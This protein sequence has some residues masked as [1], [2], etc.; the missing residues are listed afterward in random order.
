[1]RTVNPIRQI[2]DKLRDEDLNPQKKKLSL[3]IGD[4][5]VF[6]N[7]RTDKVVEEAVIRAVQSGACNGYA[8][9]MGRDD[10]RKAV[11]KRCS[12]KNHVLKPSVGF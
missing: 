8:P 6:G 12:T 1:M 7:L 2:V 9:S 3:S 11:A 5:T 4:P 10:A